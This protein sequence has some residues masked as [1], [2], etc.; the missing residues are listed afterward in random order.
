MIFYFDMAVDM[1]FLTDIIMG[2]RTAYLD[3]VSK[4][5][6]I[7]TVLITDWKLIA[8]RYMKGFFFFDII[9]SLPLELI[10]LSVCETMGGAQKVLRA[11][12]ALKVLRFVRILRL[13]R[14]T[15]L[16]VCI[17]CVYICVCVFVCPEA[18]AYH[19][20]AGM[21]CVCVCIYIYMCVC[22]CVCVCLP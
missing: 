7:D 4:N 13:L 10:L 19:E 5:K 16:Q 12:G 3:D 2:F 21:H 22:V 14:I 17:M 15:R 9:S 18:A 1:A 11:P 20:I 6:G 8:I